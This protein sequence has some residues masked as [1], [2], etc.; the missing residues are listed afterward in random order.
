MRFACLI[1]AFILC[2]S[3]FAGC[4][5]LG[6]VGVNV[7]IPSADTKQVKHKRKGPPPHA[8]AHGY[9]HKH[10]DGVELQYDT[11]LGVY[12]S[13]KMPS[14]YFYNGLYIRLTNGHWEV[15]ANLNGPWR[16]EEKGQVPYKLKKAKGE[17][18]KGKTKGY[19]KKKK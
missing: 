6:E 19:E 11:G 12:F 17:K 1:F 2:L 18:H 4:K 14:V 3:V 16:P 7:K 13:V 5:T 8:P 15:A 10:H 9:R